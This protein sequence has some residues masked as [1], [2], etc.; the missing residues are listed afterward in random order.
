MQDAK[1]ICISIFESLEIGSVNSKIG[2]IKTVGI[3]RPEGVQNVQCGTLA[4][5]EQGKT[6]GPRHR[7]LLEPGSAHY[8]SS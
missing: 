2:H 6:G 5:G 4:G 3:C 7:N 8:L 1:G